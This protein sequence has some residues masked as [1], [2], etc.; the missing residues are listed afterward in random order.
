[1]VISNEHP[2]GAFALALF[3][4]LLRLVLADGILCVEQMH[5]HDCL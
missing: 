2:D 1:M 4:S 3:Q 5:C